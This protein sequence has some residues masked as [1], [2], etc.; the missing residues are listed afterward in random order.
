MVLTTTP[1]FVHGQNYNLFET[2]ALIT[3]VVANKTLKSTLNQK[4]FPTAVPSL[5][6]RFANFFE[7]M[8]LKTCSLATKV[9]K[10]IIES[11]RGATNSTLTLSFRPKIATFLKP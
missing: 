6:L 1:F 10:L 9:L 11:K 3:N 5:F 4:V 8:A 2:M 7:T